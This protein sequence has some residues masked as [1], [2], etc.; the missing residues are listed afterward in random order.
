MKKD[1]LDAL[2]QVREMVKL[3]DKFQKQLNDKRHEAIALAE[4][5]YPIE[6]AAGV[7]FVHKNEKYLVKHTKKWDFTHVTNDP[8]FN[9]WRQIIKKQKEL[10]N[11]YDSLMKKILRR[12]PHLK[13]KSETKS[14]S[15]IR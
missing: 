9:E 3:N 1:E 14:L 11:D 5:L 7:Q 13:P 15:V 10:K 4:E 8:I 2:E 12:F 6:T